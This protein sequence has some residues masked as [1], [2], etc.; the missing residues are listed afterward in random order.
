[1]LLILP[2]FF[3]EL[4]TKPAIDCL[5]G[6]QGACEKGENSTQGTSYHQS[7][8]RVLSQFRVQVLGFWG[9]LRPAILKFN[10]R[11]KPY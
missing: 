2:H 1:M 9:L 3:P 10:L 4:K 6:M 11:A 5:K 7:G 8:F